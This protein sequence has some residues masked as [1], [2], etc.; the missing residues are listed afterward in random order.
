MIDDSP[1][2]ED[3]WIKLGKV[4][5][6]GSSNEAVEQYSYSSKEKISIPL[7]AVPAIVKG[8]AK[9]KALVAKHYSKLNTLGESVAQAGAD[10][11]TQGLPA[12]SPMAV[13]LVVKGGKTIRRKVPALRG[14]KEWAELAKS[15]AAKKRKSD[16][17]IARFLADPLRATA[18]GGIGGYLAKGKK[19]GK[20]GALAGASIGAGTALYRHFIGSRATIGKI[21]KAKK[22]GK[23]DTHYLSSHEKKLY[24]EITKKA[25]VKPAISG[26]AL[27]AALD[28]FSQRKH[29]SKETPHKDYKKARG[30]TAAI[31]GAVGGVALARLLKHI[32][33]TSGKAAAEGAKGELS[34]LGKK[35]VFK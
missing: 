3:G 22:E 21:R 9:R 2:F 26:A 16:Y 5:S 14:K 6:T 23:K 24:S 34:A 30:A 20:A 18:F 11:A 13:D 32:A 15:A 31:S 12:L 25:A 17:P 7:L 8:E 35:I 10:T 19:G 1:E 27:A 28:L 29:I 33:S 4:L